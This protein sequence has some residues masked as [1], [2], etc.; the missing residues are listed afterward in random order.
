MKASELMEAL[1][2]SELTQHKRISQGFEE[3][4]WRKEG[5]TKGRLRVYWEERRDKARA[6]RSRYTRDIIKEAT[7]QNNEPANEDAMVT[8]DQ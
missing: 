1:A 7:H 2:N 4:R 5:N 6:P 3:Q 8:D